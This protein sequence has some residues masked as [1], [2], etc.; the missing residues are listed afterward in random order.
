MH[1]LAKT[2][3][4][5]TIAHVKRGDGDTWVEGCGNSLNLKGTL[6]MSPIISIC[7]V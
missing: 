4:D 7:G 2:W 5:K 1:K 3:N 6:S